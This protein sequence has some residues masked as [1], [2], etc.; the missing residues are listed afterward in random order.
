MLRVDALRLPLIHLAAVN[1]VLAIL[2]FFLLAALLK[3]FALFAAV[4]HGSSSS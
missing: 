4:A 1:A 3:F 2:A